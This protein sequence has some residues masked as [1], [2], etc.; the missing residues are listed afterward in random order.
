MRTL[1]SIAV[2]L[3]MG[4]T[5][6]TRPTWSRRCGVMPITTGSTPSAAATSGSCVFQLKVDRTDQ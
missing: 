2:W 6:S 5:T 1:L 4:S 3:L